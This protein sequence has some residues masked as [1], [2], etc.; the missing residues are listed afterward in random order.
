MLVQLLQS[1]YSLILSN[2]AEFYNW[3]SFGFSAWL[4]FNFCAINQSNLLL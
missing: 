4:L 3:W 1:S 2:Q